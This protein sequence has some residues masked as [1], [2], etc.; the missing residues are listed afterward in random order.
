MMI[1]AVRLILFL[2]DVERTVNYTTSTI[3]FGITF[4]TRYAH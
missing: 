2:E 4:V 3:Q 1:D